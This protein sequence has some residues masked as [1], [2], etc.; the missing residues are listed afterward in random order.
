MISSIPSH[1]HPLPHTVLVRTQSGVLLGVLEQTWA[2]YSNL[3][4]NP[5][6]CNDLQ[7]L[8]IQEQS[9]PTLGNVGHIKVDKYLE[10]A[11]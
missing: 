3:I 10:N 9:Y 5:F 7:K 1:Y 6:Y 2:S 8:S 4:S 11:R